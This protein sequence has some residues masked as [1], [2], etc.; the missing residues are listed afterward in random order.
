[1][2]KYF[3]FP[4]V[5]ILFSPLAFS[6][7]NALPTIEGL[8]KQ[9]PD[10]KDT[11][12][13]NRL[14]L[15]AYNYYNTGFGPGS[16]DFIRRGDSISHYAKLAFEA[17]KKINYKKGMAEALN[18][19]ASGENIK[20]FGLGLAQKNNSA[21]M[22]ASRNYLL[23]AIAIAKEIND[24]DAMGE[25]Y[26]RWP[27]ETK[28]DT[29]DYMKKSLPYFQKAGNE[30]M[31]GVVCTW[32][33]EGYFYKGYYENAIEYCQRGLILNHKTADDAR[34]KEEQG[35][36]YYLYQQS[37]CDMADLYKVAGDYQSSLEYFEIATSSGLKGIQAGLWRT[38][39]A[40]YFV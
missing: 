36:R 20:G 37:L 4:I 24:N 6:Q 23:S 13:V 39:K 15:I 35:W 11:A 32:I 16:A 3:L 31:E 33:A 8:K 29:I 28:D 26:Y 1:M 17:A 30:H 7:T 18:Q 12:L 9:L 2:K 5:A 21:T 25:A 14:N 10:L 38:R 19:Q 40:K 27:T 22:D 34:T